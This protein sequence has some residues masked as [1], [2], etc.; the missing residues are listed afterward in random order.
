MIRSTSK[1]RVSKGLD[2]HLETSDRYAFDAV[3]DG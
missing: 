2:V 1:R 3:G